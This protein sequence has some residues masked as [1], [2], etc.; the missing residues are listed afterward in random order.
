MTMSF[1]VFSLS[2]NQTEVNLSFSN[3]AGEPVAVT[4]GNTTSSNFQ[5]D[6]DPGQAVFLET[7]GSGGSTGALARGG[8]RVSAENPVGVSGIFTLRD[9]LGGFLTETGIGTSAV[10][11][12]ATI[13]VD[14]TGSFDTGVAFFNPSDTSKDLTLKLYSEEGELLSTASCQDGVPCSLRMDPG[15]QMAKFVQEFF[16]EVPLQRGSLAI[17]GPVATI[18][19]RQ[20]SSPLSFTTMPVGEGAA[21]A[22]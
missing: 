18:T 19:L 10:R 14:N 17:I 16:Q 7:D 11:P 6:L 12:V 3:E 13:V 21:A 1:L 20:N 5:L 9:T 15:S 4:I 8:V 2:T 22:P